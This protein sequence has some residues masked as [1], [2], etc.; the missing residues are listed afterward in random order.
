M[1]NLSDLILYSTILILSNGYY[2]VCRF[3]LRVR[4]IFIRKKYS[5]YTKQGTRLSA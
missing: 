5:Q 3:E 1:H 2:G 4:I